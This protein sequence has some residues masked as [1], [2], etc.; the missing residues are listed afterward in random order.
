MPI[1]EYACGACNHRLEKLQKLADA[2]LVDCPV[3]G[4]PKLTKLVSAAGF[5]L[6][7][8]G[9]YATDFKPKSQ[10]NLSENNCPSATACGS[11][12]PGVASSE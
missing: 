10:K 8:T 11:N 3:C 4:Q 1:Y 5:Q 2:P 7:G 6:K 9:W 12:C